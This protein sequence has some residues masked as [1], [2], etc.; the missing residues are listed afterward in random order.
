[1]RSSEWSEAVAA[2]GSRPIELAQN[3]LPTT[4]A[5]CRRLFS[6]VGK[7]VETGGDDALERLRERELVGR[8]LLGVELDEL[9]RVERI[10]AGPLEQ[11]LLRLGGEQRPAEQAPDQ[12]GRL[13]VGERGERERRR[14]ELAAAPARPALEELGPRGRDD[15]QR[16]VG[17]PVDELVEEVEEA[18]VGPVDVLDDEDERALLGETLEE[19]APGGERLVPAIASELRLA[20]EAE[21][22]EEMRLDPR[23]VARAGERVLDGLVDLRRDL[24]GRVLLEDAG[25]RL[26]DLAE[27]PQRD[28]VAV[29]EAAALAPGD[30][31][32]I[33][34][35]DP[36]QL[37]DEPALADARDADEREEL[38]RALVAGPLERVA[39]DA[40][41]AFAPD[42]LGARLVRDVDAEAGIE[43]CDGRPRRG[44]ARPCPSPRPALASS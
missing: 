21:E 12:L 41:L 15:E 30:E 26:D 6:G 37:V 23:L 5:S 35:D 18:L 43:R 33:G 17:H 2:S 36:L 44:S 40:E 22:R 4:A 34:V 20:G 13:L 27:R 28:P 19:A 42:E 11:G 31:L 25:L 29:R 7:P 8:A 9:L 16:H 14:V 3:T 1:M 38:R 32:G 10:A 24:L 39:D